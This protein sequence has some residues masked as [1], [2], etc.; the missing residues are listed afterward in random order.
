MDKYGAMQRSASEAAAK[1]LGAAFEILN[2]PDAEI[3][4]RDETALQICDIIR[5]HKPDILI[6]HWS[7]SWHKDH[8]NCYLIVRDA[9]FYAGL[10]TLH[11]DTAAHAVRRLYYADNWEDADNFRPDV[12]LDISDVFEKWMAACDA[13]PM[14]RGRTGFRYNDYYSS[15]SVMRGC[16]SGFQRA[17]ALM[18]D[19]NQRTNRLRSLT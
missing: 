17:V 2:W 19:P 11:R 16:L 7:G 14:W 15:L 12:Y 3:P 13:Y 6:S 10:T 5:R 1:I 4:L 9:I 8:Q 18:T